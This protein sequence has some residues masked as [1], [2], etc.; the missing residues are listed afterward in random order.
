MIQIKYEE[1]LDYYDGILTFLALDEEGNKYF[2]HLYDD[3]KILSQYTVVKISDEDWDLYK[4]RK[5][6]MR[7]LMIKSLEY[8]LFV[9]LAEHID[10]PMTLF[11]M[12]WY[13]E[14]DYNEYF[15]GSGIYYEGI[16]T[17]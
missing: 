12:S 5:I 3:Y 11:P 8:G 14:K 4:N 6:D 13:S 7:D 2:A 15:P 9:V 1:T 10:K 17:L 16:F